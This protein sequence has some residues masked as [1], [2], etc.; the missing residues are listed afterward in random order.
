MR[1]RGVSYI[2]YIYANFNF[3]SY[4]ILKRVRQSEK[5]VRIEKREKDF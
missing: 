1:V 3:Y 2:I 4:K 5:I